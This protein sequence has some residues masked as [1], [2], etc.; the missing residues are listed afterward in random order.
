M[1]RI[2]QIGNICPGAVVSSGGLFF[3]VQ[4]SHEVGG[5][6]CPKATCSPW[7]QKRLLEAGLPHGT[8]RAATSAIRT[9]GSHF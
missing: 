3:I 5:K 9:I 7:A 4:A 1:E 6:I 8:R 2:Q